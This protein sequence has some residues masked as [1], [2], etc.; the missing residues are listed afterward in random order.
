MSMI[1]GVETVLP[2]IPRELRNRR[3][4]TLAFLRLLGDFGVKTVGQGHLVIKDALH[5]N[6][7]NAEFLTRSDEYIYLRLARIRR[8]N[9]KS[10]ESSLMFALDDLRDGCDPE[11]ITAIYGSDVYEKLLD[12]ESPIET[13]LILS[14]M[15]EKI[16]LKYSEQW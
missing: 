15:F 11:K 14:K 13:L 3:P 7:G 10:V 8:L 4:E 16:Y 12:D 9:A 2:A 6:L 5:E 1:G